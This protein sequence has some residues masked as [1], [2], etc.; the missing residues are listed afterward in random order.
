MTSDGWKH[1][2]EEYI[3]QGGPDAA[4]K[5]IESYYEERQDRR[6]AQGDTREADIFFIQRIVSFGA[7]KTYR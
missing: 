5:R 4:Q 3:K 2:L 6:G 7:D 1:D